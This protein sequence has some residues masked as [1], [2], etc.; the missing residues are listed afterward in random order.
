MIRNFLNRQ[1]RM[2]LRFF[3]DRVA[4]IVL[5]YYFTKRQIK[6]YALLKCLQCYISENIFQ[7]VLLSMITVG[8]KLG[9][10]IH[11]K[12]VNT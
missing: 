7:T 11:L 3:S 8:V 6:P 9:D 12:L 4:S 1:F 10:A 2:N 5:K